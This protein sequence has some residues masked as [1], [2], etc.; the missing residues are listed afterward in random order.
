M[1]C[2]VLVQFDDPKDTSKDWSIVSS[3]IEMRVKLGGASSHRHSSLAQ[4]MALP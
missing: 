3:N 1:Q 4:F 2:G